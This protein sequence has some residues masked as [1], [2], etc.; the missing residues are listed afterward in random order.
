MFVDEEF[1]NF[2]SEPNDIE[3]AYFHKF[4]NDLS[5]EMGYN[6]Y[7]YSQVHLKVNHV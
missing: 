7:F 2:D 1:I 5:L 3:S 6:N 4:E